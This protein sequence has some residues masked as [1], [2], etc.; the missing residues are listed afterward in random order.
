MIHDIYN[1]HQ[2]SLYDSLI[3]FTKI[4]CELPYIPPL[5]RNTHYGGLFRRWKGPTGSGKSFI[6]SGMW[7]FL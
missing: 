7:G 1:K 5:L 4:Y 3:C 6:Q 2:I